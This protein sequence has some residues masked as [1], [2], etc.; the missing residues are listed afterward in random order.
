MPTSFPAESIFVSAWE[1]GFILRSDF[2]ALKTQAFD[3]D[4]R[5]LASRLM[6]AIRRGHIS[7]LDRQP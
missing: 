7:L 6:Y 5:A 1:R 2:D 4:T 3:D